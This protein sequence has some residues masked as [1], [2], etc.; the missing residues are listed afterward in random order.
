M[1]IQ[2]VNDRFVPTVSPI[3]SCFM[4]NMHRSMSLLS[5]NFSYILGYWGV[6]KSMLF[7]FSSS[8]C[9]RNFFV[10]RCGLLLTRLSDLVMAHLKHSSS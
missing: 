8:A 4:P 10:I 3:V 6:G 7:Q 1:R 2:K 9:S 5:S